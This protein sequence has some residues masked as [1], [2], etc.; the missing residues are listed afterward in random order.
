MVYKEIYLTLKE[1]GH[2]EKALNSGSLQLEI[3]TKLWQ[4]F[5]ISY[6]NGW[7]KLNDLHCLL[8]NIIKLKEPKSIR[9]I[10][11]FIWSQKKSILNE[12]RKGKV[13]PL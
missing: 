7:E 8:N 4:H 9:E 5:C 11:Q 6:L 13:L 2:L 1:N 10:I 3:H 12:D